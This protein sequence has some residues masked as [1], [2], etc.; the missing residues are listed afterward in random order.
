MG[1]LSKKVRAM[2]AAAAAL[3][4]AASVPS[5]MQKPLIRLKV[6]CVR[7]RAGR[8]RPCTLPRRRFTGFKVISN[9]RF[10]AQF[11]EAVANP[12]EILLFSKARKPVERAWRRG[13]PPPRAPRGVAWGPFAQAKTR[14]MATRGR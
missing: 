12:A 14:L 11:N 5:D 1:V 6:E 7:A 13:P 8:R 4:E 3:P 2:I 9:Q 10:G